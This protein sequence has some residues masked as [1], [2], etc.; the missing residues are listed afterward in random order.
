M[1]AGELEVNEKNSRHRGKI[2][3]ELPPFRT[4]GIE[5]ALVQENELHLI[6]RDLRTNQ[7]D[8]TCSD[9]FT[10]ANTFCEDDLLGAGG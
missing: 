2:K 10:A 9:S 1:H 8:R 6:F 7:S 3:A 5:R 4:L